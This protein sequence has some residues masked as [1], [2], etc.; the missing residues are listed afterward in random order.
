MLMIFKHQFSRSIVLTARPHQNSTVRHNS[1]Q[2]NPLTLV[3]EP[4]SDL[5]DAIFYAVSGNGILAVSESV[6]SDPKNHELS[7]GDFA[8]VPAWTEHQIKNE[9]DED[10]V[11]LVIQSGP[12]PIRADLTDWGGDMVKTRK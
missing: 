2:G 10:V 11:F 8:F 1:E 7:P 4:H 12:T 9:T 5:V 3:S 6:D